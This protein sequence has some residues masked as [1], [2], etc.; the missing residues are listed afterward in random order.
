MRILVTNDDGINASQLIP[1]IRCCKKLGDVTVIVPKH[2]QSG[3]SLGIELRLPFEVK[4]VQLAE[5]I[6]A[7]SV[8]STPADCVRFAILGL[9]KE[10]DLVISGINCGFNIGVD[11]QYSGTAGAAL[12]AANLGVKAIALSTSAENYD[13]S[14]QDLDKVFDFIFDNKLLDIYGIYNVNI[15]PNPLG[16]RFTRQGG[17]YY[18]DDFEKIGEDLYIARGMNVYEE[19]E[20]LTLDTDATLKGYVSIMPLAVDKT[21]MEVYKEL[22][23]KFGQTD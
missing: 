21:N 14:T 16:I 10:F 17:A 19:K 22:C 7:L 4:E 5:D 23:E 18:S 15:P 1:L 12:E 9:K 2:E 6:C 11:T 20:G 8:D 3:K 13:H